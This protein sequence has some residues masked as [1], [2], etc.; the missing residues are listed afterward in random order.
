MLLIHQGV[1]NQTPSHKIAYKLAP[2]VKTGRKT[3][4]S[5]FWGILYISNIDNLPLYLHHII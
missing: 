1:D 4:V 3:Y 5:D 2:L